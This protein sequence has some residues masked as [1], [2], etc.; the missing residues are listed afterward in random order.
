M[1]RDAT[2]VYFNCFRRSK[3]VLRYARSAR[4][5]R[6]HAER[7][8]RVFLFFSREWRRVIGTGM[9]QARSAIIHDER[10]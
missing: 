7:T 4:R 1:H 8:I 3:E 6:V 2:V 5:S 10:Y 9:A